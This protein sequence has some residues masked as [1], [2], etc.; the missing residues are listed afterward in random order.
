[1]SIAQS[2]KEYLFSSEKNALAPRGVLR[3]HLNAI[4]SFTA[5]SYFKIDQERIVNLG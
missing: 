3:F 1:M 4:F 2:G 5:L